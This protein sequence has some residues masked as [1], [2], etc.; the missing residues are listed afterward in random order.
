MA[1]TGLCAAGLAIVAWTGPVA[2]DRP[3]AIT[4]KEM[5]PA[6]QTIRVLCEIEAEGIYR[7]AKPAE[8]SQT[9]TYPMK[10]AGRLDFDE[11]VDKVDGNGRPVRAYR[12]VHQAANAINN[13]VRKFGSQIRPE[14]ALLVAER[15]QEGVVVSSV[16]GPLTR[17]ELDLVQSTADSLSL[18]ALLPAGAVKEGDRW[19]VS[20]EAALALSDYEVLA[21]NLLE[22]KLEEVSDRAARITLGGEIRGATR[23]GE[24][25][26]SCKGTILFDRATA[27]IERLTLERV[28]RREPGPVEHGLDVKSKLTNER[29]VIEAPA[30]LSDAVVKELP[31]DGDHQRELLTLAPPNGKYTL[32]HDREW[33]LVYD[34]DRQVVLKRL[35]H[36]EVMAQCNLAFGPN[37][38]KGKHQDLEQF[39][40]DIRKALGKRFGQ[41]VAA[42]EVEG[43][44]GGGGGFRYKVSVLGREG[45]R[46]ILWHYYLIASPEGEQVLVTFTLAKDQEKRFADQDARMMGS[47]EWHAASAA[48]KPR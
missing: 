16:G 31:A 46:E 11:R 14:V 20:D 25:V 39:R 27:R 33:Y 36:G 40:D 19:K 48:D 5:R 18:P 26:I 38:G 12:R 47:L 23:G 30:E 10:V 3:G 13:A 41:I 43:A 21:T 28:E 7:P 29:T 6:G 2:A 9:K 45:E 8:G 24:G 42:G 22:A 17:S 34:D 35:D 44:P 37:A 4:L 32:L 15:R 1:R